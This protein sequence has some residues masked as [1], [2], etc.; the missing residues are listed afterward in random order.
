MTHLKI[1]DLAPDFTLPKNGGGVVS[2]SEHRGKKVV[3]YFYPQDDTQTCTLQAIDFTGKA[4]AFRTAGAT[5]IG[6]SPDSVK[7]HD[8]FC[9]KH[10]LGITL[11]A[12]EDRKVIDAYDV[13]HQK[14]TFGITYMGVVRSTFLIDAEGRI[15]GVWDNVRLK[16]HVDTVLE[17]AKAL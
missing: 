15:A 7:K 3:L 5:V 13:W 17:A 1:G 12:D 9:A 4:E 2:L 8:K 6:V 11:G 10:K 16:N 14:K